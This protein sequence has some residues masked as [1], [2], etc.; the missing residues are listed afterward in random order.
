MEIGTN[1]E[2]TIYNIFPCPIYRTKREPALLPKEEKEIKEI[3]DKGI[4]SNMYN[5]STEDT[6]IFNSKLKNLKHFCEEHIKLYVNKIISPKNKLEFYITQSWLNIS[7][8]GESHHS[9]SH[10]NSIISGA[11]YIATEETDEI[12]FSDPNF[13]VKEILALE[14]KEY[15]IWNSGTCSFSVN[16]NEL[17]LFPSWLHHG[18]EANE[19][20]TTNRISLSFNTFIRGKIGDKKLLTELI[21]K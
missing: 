15:N 16:N 7:K 19:K 10:P 12:T 11:F 17:V 5:S 8:P 21:L 6:Y 1:L 18:V 3:F 4:Y 13:R 9:H 20:A 14:Q 2:H